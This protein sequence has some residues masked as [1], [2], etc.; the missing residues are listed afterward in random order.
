MIHYVWLLDADEYAIT[1]KD[2][3]I[4]TPPK[5]SEAKVLHLSDTVP[6]F[7]STVMLDQA[8]LKVTL[9]PYLLPVAHTARKEDTPFLN[10]SHSKK[11]KK[12]RMGLTQVLLLP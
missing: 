1:H 8:I 5:F 12:V 3:S 9:N 10:V 4:K 7:S 2:T 11:I 6:K